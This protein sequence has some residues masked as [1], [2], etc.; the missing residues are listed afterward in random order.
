LLRSQINIAG[1]FFELGRLAESEA[2]NRSVLLS[3]SLLPLEVAAAAQRSLATVLLSLGRWGESLA[4]AR[5][6]RQEFEM[7][8]IAAEARGA[9]LIELVAL[10]SLGFHQAAHGL[11]DFLIESV[12]TQTQPILRAHLWREMG[13][14]Y[15]RD[16]HEEQALAA[17]ERS[18]NLAISVGADD[19]LAHTLLDETAASVAWNRMDR[20]SR[21]M[22]TLEHLL[23]STVSLELRV[24]HAFVQAMIEAASATDATKLKDARSRLREASRWSGSADLR[25]WTWRC[26]AAE[27][28]LSARLADAGATAVATG[29]ARD[30]L[31]D[32]LTAIGAEVLQES[33]IVLPDPQV[34][35]AWCDQIGTESDRQRGRSYLEVFLQ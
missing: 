14:V 23:S 18:R 9:A 5:Q 4:R 24:V 35:L 25:P 32:L 34:F 15:W 10:Q 13:H 16:S 2:L 20:A 26:Q 31:R 30:S 27:A 12:G 6:A 22:E 7:Q 19:E 1:V 17:W 8:G 21:N 29:K 3:S 11:A 33:Y 28:G